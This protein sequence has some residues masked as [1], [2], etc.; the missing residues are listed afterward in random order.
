MGMHSH[1]LP[2]PG[3]DLTGADPTAFPYKDI[4]DQMSMYYASQVF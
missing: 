3:I 1:H 2:G 4:T